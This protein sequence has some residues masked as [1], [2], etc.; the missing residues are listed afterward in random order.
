MGKVMKGVLLGGLVGAAVAGVKSLQQDQPS[1]EGGSEVAKTA[2]GGAAIGG[3]IGIVLQRREKKRQAKRR[4]KLGSALTAGGLVEAARAARPV[5]EQAAETAREK[6]SKAAEAARPTL[7][8]AADAARQQASKAAAAAQARL[9][10][11]T[12]GQRPV[13]VRLG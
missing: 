3:L 9:D 6:A 12:D 13:L 1:E 11:A 7:E 8:Q 10:D 5:L 4:L 2:M